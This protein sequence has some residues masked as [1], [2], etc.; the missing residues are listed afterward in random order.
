LHKALPSAPIPAEFAPPDTK[1]DPWSVDIRVTF[2][3]IEHATPVRG[4][5]DDARS[6]FDPSANTNTELSAIVTGVEAFASRS[7]R[8][9]VREVLR[10]TIRLV[11]VFPVMIKESIELFISVPLHSVKTSLTTLTGPKLRLH[12]SINHQNTIHPSKYLNFLW[13]Q[14]GSFFRDPVASEV[15]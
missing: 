14:C 15:I 8:R 11:A 12:S 3:S 13:D 6:T 1:S 5:G 2:D 10:M 9:I 7:E 4:E